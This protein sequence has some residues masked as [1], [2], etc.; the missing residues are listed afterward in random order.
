MKW[1]IRLY[2]LLIAVLVC[3]AEVED[4]S[5]SESDAFSEENT[6]TP[7]PQ[8]SSPSPGNLLPL[9]TKKLPIP[10]LD[11]IANALPGVPLKPHHDSDEDDLDTDGLDMGEANFEDGQ[12]VLEEKCRQ[13]GGDDAVRDA[14]LAKDRLVECAQSLV[15]VSELQHEIDANKR[16]GELDTVFKKH[17]RKVPTFQECLHNFTTAIDPCLKEEER[18]TKN[19][20]HNLTDAMLGFVCFKEGDRIALFIAEGGPDCMMEKQ[21][22]VKN[23]LNSTLSRHLPKQMPDAESLPSFVIEEQQCKEMIEMRDCVVKHLEG[24]KEPTPA[25]IVESMMNYLMKSSPCQQYMP[26]N[27]SPKGSHHLRKKRTAIL[28]CWEPLLPKITSLREENLPENE[29]EEKMCK[30]LQE[31]RNCLMK[32]LK[33]E[34]LPNLAKIVEQTFNS[35]LSL[36]CPDLDLES[37]S[38]SGFSALSHILFTSMVALSAL[39]FM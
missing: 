32:V 4:V 34:D 3:G 31:F 16:N 20:M 12:K 5:V 22:E 26:V 13:L 19:L 2:F 27:S 1:T 36:E 37:S 28:H 35:R 6:S 38:P 21:N 25:N 8:K 11:A 29:K 24:C 17:C 23:C 33:T 18:V 15:N 9:D 7:S 30:Y 14:T 10:S 39:A